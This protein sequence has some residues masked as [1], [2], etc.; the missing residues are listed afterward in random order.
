MTLE[1]IPGLAKY[2][3]ADDFETAELV[4]V[5]RTNI[6]VKVKRPKGWSK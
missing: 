5:T 1:E 3:P 2:L 6:Q 4:G